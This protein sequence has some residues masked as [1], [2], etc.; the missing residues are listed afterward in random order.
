M[1]Q[2]DLSAVP[3]SSHQPCLLA[4]PQD[5]EAPIINT[6]SAQPGTNGTCVKGQALAET[7][8][9]AGDPDQHAHL[10]P[11]YTGMPDYTAPPAAAFQ[12][13]GTTTRPASASATMPGAAAK[14]GS[15]RSPARSLT[16]SKTALPAVNVPEAQRDILSQSDTA[17]AAVPTARAAIRQPART[18]SRPS[19]SIPQAQQEAMSQSAAQRSPK[20][21]LLRDQHMP[22]QLLHQ[23]SS[24]PPDIFMRHEAA[25]TSP[26]AM[27][28]TSS[29]ASIFKELQG[30]TAA[31]SGTQPQAAVRRSPKP[32]LLRDQHMP[33]EL[34][35]QKTAF[36]SDVFMRHEAACTS[37]S[38]M[39]Q[40]SSAASIFK[41]LQGTTAAESGTQPQAAARRSPKPTL[42][43]G[44]HMPGEL[45]HQ[46]T[47]FPSDVFMRHEA[48]TQQLPSADES[49]KASQQQQQAALPL[50]QQTATAG[51]PLSNWA[52]SR[53]TSPTAASDA[54]SSVPAS[55]TML[56]AAVSVVLPPPR[57]D[58]TASEMALGSSV[59]GSVQSPRR[60][61]SRL[62][63]SS[64]RSPRTPRP[65]AE[66]WFETTSHD[67]ARNKSW[68]T[69]WLAMG[70]QEE[71]AAADPQFAQL[72][73]QSKGQHQSL[74]QQPV[75]QATLHPTTQQSP[76]QSGL[77]SSHA[78]EMQSAKPSHQSQQLPGIQAAFSM[79]RLQLPILV[80][81]PA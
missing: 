4:S 11:S 52:S 72:L 7:I 38:A 3:D 2:A 6:H 54:T 24:F 39:Q 71:Q 70:A 28:Q 68:A 74:H 67:L 57:S 43:R 13:T 81:K 29:A 51:R 65:A 46:K 63:Q 77:V 37:P 44:Q 60:G 22:G 40:T 32:M 10:L 79:P 55:V 34:L 47:A 80:M 42:L 73:Q 23:K 56:P 69:E 45:L 26:S 50:P 75:H 36:P 53:P 61:S 19:V 25:C 49:V 17:A 12:M 30:T 14:A 35:H 64:K 58:S 33:G 66:P 16:R 15:S 9:Q 78:P 5:P 76:R 21:T 31:E 1:L 59:Q 48:A 41:E 8:E 18:L 62:K 20:P 27:Q